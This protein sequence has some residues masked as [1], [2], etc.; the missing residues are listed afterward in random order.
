MSNTKPR[1]SL[2]DA[3]LAIRLPQVIRDQLEVVAHSQYMSSSELVRQLIIKAVRE[4]QPFLSQP[5]QQ[6]QRQ[7]AKP[8]Y[9]TQ[10]TSDDD[11]EY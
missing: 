2:N 8:S 5:M 3:V 6:G 7:P 1:K 9:Q 4:A 11:W 10:Q